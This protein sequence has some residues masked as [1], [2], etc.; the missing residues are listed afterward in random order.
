MGNRI[1]A[2]KQGDKAQAWAEDQKLSI[3]FVLQAAKTK[4]AIAGLLRSSCCYLININAA[5]V[6]SKTI[7]TAQLKKIPPPP[8]AA[9]QDCGSANTLAPNPAITAAAASFTSSSRQNEEKRKKNTYIQN[10]DKHTFKSR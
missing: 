7:S 5:E 8:P 1:K 3:P 2:A 9:I 10:Y 4:Q 6:G